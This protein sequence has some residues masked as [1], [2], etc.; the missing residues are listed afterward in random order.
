[1]SRRAP[2][3]KTPE[4]TQVW[5]FPIGQS[6]H[7]A[8]TTLAATLEL[9]IGDI[10]EDD[11]GVIVNPTNRRL[12]GGGMVDLAIRRAAGPRLAS[13]CRAACEQRGGL[14]VG[15]TL[16]TPGFDLR[17]GYVVHCVLPSYAEDPDRAPA[18]L[19]SCCRRAIQ[20]ARAQGLG[21]IAFPAIATG[22]LGYPINQAAP[23]AMKAVIEEV[24]REPT[25]IRV[26]FILFGPAV[27]DAYVAAANTTLLPPK[28][29][30]LDRFLDT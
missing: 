22:V 28:Q 15:E 27:L 8:P 18:L 16:M 14:A 26:R 23:V 5:R 25:P 10:T 30:I 19:E 12:D 4:A 24:V 21:S 17:A 1:M 6:A 3:E 9:R 11:S 7:S 20:L 29:E 2:L 13:A